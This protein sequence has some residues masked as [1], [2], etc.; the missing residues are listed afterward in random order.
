MC[1]MFT[2]SPL[3]RFFECC[4][5][6]QRSFRP[7]H[8]YWFMRAAREW[9]IEDMLMK[10]TIKMGFTAKWSVKKALDICIR[11]DSVL[12]LSSIC[13]SPPFRSKQTFREEDNVNRPGLSWR[14]FPYQILNSDLLKNIPWASIADGHDFPL[15]FPTPETPDLSFLLWSECI[16]FTNR[17]IVSVSWSWASILFPI[18][19]DF[20]H[21]LAFLTTVL[22]FEKKT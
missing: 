12:W 21:K 10:E 6:K 2:W 5:R 1:W 11:W 18:G 15:V 17:L 4:L 7:D 8:L 3:D 13:G 14:N 16:R 9:C 19:W 20:K 22:F